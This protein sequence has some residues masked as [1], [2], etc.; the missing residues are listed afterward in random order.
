MKKLVFSILMCVATISAKA[1]IL[2]SEIINNI[3]EAVSNQSDGDFVFNADKSGSNITSMYVYKKVCN[4]QN[5]VTLIPHRKY[6]YAYAADGTLISRIIYHWSENQAAWTSAARYDFTL[7][8]G[9]YNIEYSRYKPLA[10]A[11]DQPV[12]KMV[13]TLLPDDSADYVCCY[14]RNRPSSPFQLVSETYIGSE[15]LLMARK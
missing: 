3:Y 6:D 8:E 14:H 5:I 9:K 2:T 13:Y 4:S 12:E 10:Q 1:Q 11:F 15:P 7:A